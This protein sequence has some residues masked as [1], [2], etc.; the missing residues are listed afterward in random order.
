MMEV[1][2]LEEEV[3]R[4]NPGQL[5]PEV[6]LREPVDTAVWLTSAIVKE[7]R[8]CGE[9]YT[10]AALAG[11]CRHWSGALSVLRRFCVDTLSIWAAASHHRKSFDL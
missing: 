9:S 7:G 2:R 10:R 1:E 5:P 3:V 8:P 6:P 11:P 4:E